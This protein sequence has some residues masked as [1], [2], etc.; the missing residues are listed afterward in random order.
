MVVPA[1]Q[2]L[3]EMF[4][5]DVAGKE[6]AQLRRLINESEEIAEQRDGLRKRLV[7][8]TKAA[9]EINAFV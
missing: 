2:M 9:K 8:L 7:L 5:E 1:K 3:L 4:Q 6:E